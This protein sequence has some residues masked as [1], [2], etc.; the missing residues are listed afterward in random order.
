MKPIHFV[1]R[2]L[3]FVLALALVAATPAQ[4][5]NRPYG[6]GM[7]QRLN[8][9]PVRLGVITTTG[10]STTNATT[11]SAFTVTGGS[12]LMVTCDAAAVFTV[13]SS[14]S[15]SYTNAAFGTVMAAGVPRYFIMRTTDTAIAVASAV[16]V[17]CAVH[18]MN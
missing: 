1:S 9:V 7:W 11:A 16:T 6:D 4:A 15:T 13:G 18:E 12:V 5:A 14:A 3:G 10:A 8:G 2:S 17:N